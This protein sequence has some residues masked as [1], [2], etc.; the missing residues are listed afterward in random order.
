M[1]SA[2][3][4][5]TLMDMLPLFKHCFKSG[6]SRG[7]NRQTFLNSGELKTKPSKTYCCV[8]NFTLYGT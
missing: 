6:R 7:N 3:A 2:K 4:E 5:P 8:V 1:L